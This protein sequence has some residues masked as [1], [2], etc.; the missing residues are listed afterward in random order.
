[1][2][3]E[4]PIRDSYRVADG[5]L[6]G[7][8]P[9]SSDPE[10]AVRRL[11]AFERYGI[12]LFVDLTHPA[13]PLEPY[14]RLLGAGARRTSHPIVDLGTPTIPH[15]TRILDEVD[16]ALAARETVY[17]HCW[18]GIGRTGTVVGCW[19]VRHGLDGGD[20]IARIAELR[21]HV[22]DAFVLSPQ[23]A[24]QRAMVRAW[25]PGR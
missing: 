9:G 5:L 2:R 19:L 11:G 3:V 18:G 25:R 23:T 6:A 17:V 7:E 13:D 20:A 1:M 21:R 16:A 12:T 22:S 14:V 24:A 15:M 10:L 8:Y 4:I